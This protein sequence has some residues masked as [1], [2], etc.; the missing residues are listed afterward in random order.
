MNSYIIAL[1]Q[2]WFAARRRT[3]RL[4]KR[5]ENINVISCLMC[6]SKHIPTIPVTGISQLISYVR[7][8]K[9]NIR[10]QPLDSIHCHGHCCE[11]AVSWAMTHSRYWVFT[12]R[13]LSAVRLY[14]RWPV[15]RVVVSTLSST[16]LAP[17]KNSTQTHP[18]N[19]LS[20]SLHRWMNLFGLT[21]LRWLSTIFHD[22]VCWL[23]FSFLMGL[24]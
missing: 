22:W 9:V 23:L 20:L 1:F 8:T 10:P 13:P 7:W 2:A 21:Q 16:K 24:D 19:R 3:T 14:L 5:I 17:S 6:R 18:S 4:H 12:P 11:S 15:D